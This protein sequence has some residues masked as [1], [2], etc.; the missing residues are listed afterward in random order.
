MPQNADKLPD[1]EI[2]LLKRWINGGALE[3]AGSKAAAPKPKKV[4]AAES[5]PGK[6]P[7]V[8]PM[9]P[10]HGLGAG[11]PNVTLA[12]GPFARDESLGTARG[13][14]QPTASATLQHQHARAGRRVSVS[15]RSAERGSLQSR[16]PVASG[17]RRPPA[18][19]GKV[20]VW[21][22]TTGERVFEVGKE[23]DAVL[24]ADISADHKRIALGGPQQRREMY[25]TETGEMLIRAHEAHRLGARRRVQPRWRAARNR[26]PQRRPLRVGSR[27]RPRIS[28]T[29]R[30]HGGRQCGR[31]ARRFEHAGIR[32]GRRDVAP[33]GDGKR[34]GGEELEC[35]DAGA[36]PR[37]HSRWPARHV[38]PRSGHSNL[39]SG[40]QTTRGD[41][42]DRRAGGERR[43]L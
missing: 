6:R 20:V 36:R 4:I 24:A 39:G 34:H 21:D 42:T 27:Q 26:R 23:L 2:D 8:I 32:I 43:L 22:I 38:R 35:Q 12:D 19:S 13:R 37:F 15:R 41:K 18:A 25:S 7:D 3:N 10:R 1:S 28:D 31:L 30:P 9:P 11:V 40:R 33:V 5:T 17:R 29:C 16:R 14:R